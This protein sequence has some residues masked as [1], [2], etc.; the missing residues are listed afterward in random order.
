MRKNSARIT[1][2]N[3]Q[4]RDL[5]QRKDAGKEWEK[6]PSF[7]QRFPAV[8]YDQQSD[9]GTYGFIEFDVTRSGYL[10]L[11]VCYKYQGNESGNWTQTRL[12][13]EDFLKQG[14]QVVDNAALSGSLVRYESKTD[15]REQIIL[16]KQVKTGEKYNLRCNKHDPPFVILFK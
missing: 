6:V 9:K 15:R 1:A 12:T 2:V 10:F 13:K 8:I 11:A 7:F 5:K 14:W 16:V 3:Y 4:P